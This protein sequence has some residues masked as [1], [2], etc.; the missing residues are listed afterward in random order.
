MVIFTQGTHE[1]PNPPLAQ[2]LLHHKTTQIPVSWFT[3]VA[4]FFTWSRFAGMPV[5]LSKSTHVLGLMESRRVTGAGHASHRAKVFPAKWETLGP[6][7]P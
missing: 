4:A 7:V 5:V 6:L 2:T 3:L 1:H